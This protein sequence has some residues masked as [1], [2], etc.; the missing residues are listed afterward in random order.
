M[1][2]QNGAY[3]NRNFITINM[4]VTSAQLSDNR[5]SAMNINICN[6]TQYTGSV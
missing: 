4:S 1:P 5:V 2:Q 3:K 6:N